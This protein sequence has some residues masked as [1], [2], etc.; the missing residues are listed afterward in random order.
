MNYMNIFFSLGKVFDDSV[1]GVLCED[2][3]GVYLFYVVER[4]FFGIFVYLGFV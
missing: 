4:M 1:V 3:I 2:W